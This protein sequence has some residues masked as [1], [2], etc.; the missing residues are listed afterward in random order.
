MNRRQLRE[1]LFKLLFRVEFVTAKEMA[2]QET[3]FFR[4]SDEIT[5]SEKDTEYITQKCANVIAKIAEIDA[6]I[7]DKAEG[8]TLAR[9]GKV[10]ITILRLAIYEMLY[11][12]DVPGSVAIN[13]AVELAKKFGQDESASFINGILA[14]FIEGNV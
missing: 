12:E 10:D 6:M 5:F 3:L 11:D 7:D 4:T 8:W 1:Q 2:E 13:E 9:I 14:K